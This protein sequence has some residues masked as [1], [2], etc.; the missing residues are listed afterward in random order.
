M[1]N[2][3]YIDQITAIRA[4]TLQALEGADF[5]TIAHPD[6]GWT[7]KDI[8]THLTFWDEQITHSLEAFLA[9]E[10]YL[11]PEELRVRNVNDVVREQRKAITTTQ[12]M[13]AFHDATE[14]FKALVSSVP[15]EQ[16]EV[17]FKAPWGAPTTL[18]KTVQTMVH[19]DTEHR[20]EIL[21][22]RGLTSA[23]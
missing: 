1:N 3:N 9:G 16:F 8:V 7:I 21:A 4:E 17:E 14:R 23:D 6:S 15:P 2:Q 22:A 18:T 12:V 10:S 5:D 19:H 20:Q 11:M 13:S